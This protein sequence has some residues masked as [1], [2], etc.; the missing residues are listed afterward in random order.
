MRSNF[1]FSH[2]PGQPPR[3]LE[4]KWYFLFLRGFS[5]LRWK[6]RQRMLRVS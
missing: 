2:R 4:T 5:W 3:A 6:V 1:G